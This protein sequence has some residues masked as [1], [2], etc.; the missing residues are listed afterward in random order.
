METIELSEINYL[1]VVVAGLAHT[2]VGLAWYSRRLFGD[3]W[4]E[5]THATLDPAAKWLPVAAVGHLVIALV[6]AILI[7]FAGG[8]SLAAGL[9][10]ALL[11]WIGFV[12]TLE[13]GEL[14]WE[15]IR[16]RLFAI[17]VGEHLVALS[18]AGAILGLW[19]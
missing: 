4:V 13:I 16:F 2:L 5:L 7:R 1:A 19:R 3:A 10:V 15:K 9:V 6:L 11:A 14:V 17:R 18:L 12:V 8:P